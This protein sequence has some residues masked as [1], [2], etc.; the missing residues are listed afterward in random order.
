MKL[1]I[2]LQNHGKKNHPLWYFIKIIKGGSLQLL[3][4]E[5]SSEDSFN[6]LDIGVQDKEYTFK[7]K[8]YSIFP[9]SNI[10]CHVEPYHHLKYKSFYHSGESYQNHGIIKVFILFNKIL[11]QKLKNNSQNKIKHKVNQQINKK[12]KCK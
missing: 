2:R 6:M 3:I 10:G 11:I 8:S 5:I 4:V 12:E 7:D 9:E 1:A